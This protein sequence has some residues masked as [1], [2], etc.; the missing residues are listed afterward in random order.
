MKERKWQDTELAIMR[1]I[2]LL[3]TRTRKFLVFRI[4]FLSIPMKI[5]GYGK[6][7]GSETSII[8]SLPGSPDRRF[9]LALKKLH[10]SGGLSRQFFQKT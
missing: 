5:S 9:V 4:P 6:T 3:I 10:P 2:F 8:T 1:E 7:M